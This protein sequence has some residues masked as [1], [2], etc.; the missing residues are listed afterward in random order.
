MAMNQRYPETYDDPSMDLRSSVYDSL[1]DPANDPSQGGHSTDP[2]PVPSPAPAPTAAPAPASPRT[3]A[4]TA[5]P[6]LSGFGGAGGGPTFDQEAIGNAYRQYTGR[7]A[8]E[9]DFAAHAQNAGGT[10]G[11]ID[12][13][14]NSREAKGFSAGSRYQQQMDALNGEK[15]QARRAQMADGIAR[16]VATDLKNQGH[17]VA[18][19]GS[20]LVVDGRR[21]AVAGAS[22]NSPNTMAANAGSVPSNG[23]LSGGAASGASTNYGAIQGSGPGGGTRWEGYNA[24]RASASGDPDSAKDALFR[25]GSSLGLTLEP[26]QP[27]EYYGAKLNELVTAG[28][29]AGLQIEPGNGFDT[30]MLFT[31]ERGWEEVDIIGD[32]GGGDPRFNYQ[33]LAERG[34]AAGGGGGTGTFQP[35]APGAEG[36][37]PQSGQPAPAAVPAPAPAFTPT[38]PTYT[39]GEIGMDDIPDFT[40]DS[41]L[42]QMGD[43]TANSED[44]ANLPSMD[45]SPVEGQLET[46]ISQLLA[47]PESMDA[48]MVDNLKGRE[49]DTIAQQSA[50][51][52]EEMTRTGH[53]M[54]IADSPWLAGERLTAKRATGDA[55]I[56]GSRD[57]DI[58]AAKTNK[59]DRRLAGD[60]GNTFVDAQGRRQI[61]KRTQVSTEVQNRESN[62]FNEAKLKSD[63]V[64]AAAKASLDKA[65]IVG[66]RLKLRESVKQAAAELGQ[67]ADKMMADYITAM[68]ED[69]TKRYGID[70]S[71]EIDIKTLAQRGLEHKEEM[72]LAL[73]E[74]RERARKNDM[75][76]GTEVTAMG[77]QAERDG[78]DRYKWIVENG[79]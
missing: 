43:Y 45:A 47:D 60:L 64:A 53:Q 24:E 20:T 5:G 27:R 29:A 7:D 8:G 4:P 57:I 46:F 11:V 49:R 76:Y 65:A 36:F 1:M 74:L 77:Q 28:K 31:K 30:V 56:R 63:N 13:V 79:G 21:Y 59:E 37:T 72:A 23:M 6:G 68:A 70:V 58:E 9:G 51:L 16:T 15:D 50:L 18:W 54:G 78:W 71:K 73:A 52:D 61:A 41:L 3:A 33:P 12:A 34:M 35:T 42:A 44:P 26:N 10:A 40:R 67:S 66:D 69:L 14:K 17:E 38:A 22:P 55:A 39:A 32:A 48:E 19:E 25:V 75:D 62:R 2:V